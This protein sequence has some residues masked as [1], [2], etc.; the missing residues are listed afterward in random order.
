MV[1][2]V[3]GEKVKIENVILETGIRYDEEDSERE[4]YSRLTKQVETLTITVPLPGGKATYLI[5]L[6]KGV[7]ENLE[8]ACS[9]SKKS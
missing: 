5:D 1:R 9:L 8:M 3:G 4:H 7:K 2:R 6:P